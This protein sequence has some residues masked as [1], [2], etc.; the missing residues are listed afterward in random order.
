LRDL[1]RQ[2]IDRTLQDLEIF[3]DYEVKENLKNILY[4]W[5]KDNNEFS[6]RQGMNEILAI[7]VIAF[8]SEARQA[9]TYNLEYS[10]EEC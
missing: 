6:Y 2:D 7:I 10:E 3:T 5:A 1:I 8:L 4:L 9:P